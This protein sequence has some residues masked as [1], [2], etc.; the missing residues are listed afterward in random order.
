MADYKTLSDSELLDLLKASNHAAFTEVFNRYNSVLY[1]HAYNK[2]RSRQES[3]DVVQDAF[4]T[5]WSKREVIM[6]DENLA[7]YL[8]TIVRHKVLD[9]VKHKRIRNTYASVVMAT[10]QY[11]ATTDHLVREKQ[12]AQLINQEIAALPPRMR[13]VFELRKKEFLPNKKIAA[14]LSISEATV[15]D[16]MKKALKILKTRLSS[17]FL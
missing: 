4:V 7:G 3:L 2:I 13:E 10:E 12:Y 17:L 9:L 14:R 6:S 1:V 5:L 8:Y 11:E 15:A 16:Q